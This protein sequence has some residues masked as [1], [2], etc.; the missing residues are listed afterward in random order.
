[1]K[2][3]RDPD[4][5]TA[6]WLTEALVSTGA[7]PHGRVTS[8]H[9]QLLG[10][11]K[12]MTGPIAR[13]RLVY[14]RELVDAPRSIIAKFSASDP[15]DRALIHGMGFYEREVRFYDQLAS[16]SHLRTPRCYFSALDSAE[17]LALLLLEDL[18][19]ARN[20]S[21]LAGCSVAEAELA[22]HALAA[23]HA[24]WWQHP[25]LENQ[26]WL[27]LRSLVSVEQA[28]AFFEQAWEPFLAMCGAPVAS[29]IL[30]MGAWLKQY[31]SR[32]Y[33][34]LYQQS[35]CTL[36]HND[37]HAD[38]LFFAN[39]G[40]TQ[41]PI[42]IDWQLATRGRA[43]LDVAWFIAGHL[44]AR[45]RRSHEVHLLQSYHTLLVDSGVRDYS[46]EQCWDDYRLALL[47]PVSRIMSVVGIG[48]TTEAQTRGFC[49][50]IVPR[51]CQAA[52]DLQIGDVLHC[53]FEPSSP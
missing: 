14:D 3:P 15:E 42:V 23:F 49:D 26:H 52:H 38:N 53:V 34:Y 46:F 5:L 28:P 19:V 4:D 16:R 47:Q 51:Y 21:W 50:V 10:S 41:T 44:E 11:D 13:V 31:L 6:E 8:H 40:P 17:G 24:A 37:Y 32:V 1:V 35:P 2:I 30:Q 33:A 45:D 48:G 29:E 12:G 9:I 22:V 36:I 20:G 39:A 43:V 18:A 27:E 25:H 7:L